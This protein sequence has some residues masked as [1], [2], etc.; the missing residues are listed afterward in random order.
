MITLCS[1][2]AKAQITYKRINQDPCFPF[3]HGITVLSKI[4][5]KDSDWLIT[6]HYA[7]ISVLWP[8]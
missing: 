7:K 2:E 4:K 6:L 3:Q 8:L 1:L 5:M